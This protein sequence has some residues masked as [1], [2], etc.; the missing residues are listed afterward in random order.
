MVT[1]TYA[2]PGKYP[3]THYTEGT[4]TPL[5]HD[6]LVIIVTI[7]ADSCDFTAWFQYRIDSINC[8]EVRFTNYSAPMSPTMHFSWSFGDGSSSTDGNPVHVYAQSGTYYVCLV[9]Q[10]GSNC[11]KEYC[12]SVQVNCGH[13]DT[14]AVLPYFSWATDSATTNKTVFTNRTVAADASVHYTWDFG[15][16]SGSSH[17]IS[18]SHVYAHTGTYSVCLVAEENGGCRKQLCMAVTVTGIKPAINPCDS[19]RVSFTYSRN[20]TYPN[21][22]SFKAVSNDSSL[23]QLWSFYKKDANNINIPI[24]T[25]AQSNP[26]WT[27]TDTGWYRVCLVSITASNCRKEYCDS[28]HIEKVVNGPQLVVSTPNPAINTVTIEVTLDK[29]TQVMI[30]ILD[31]SGVTRMEF[32]ENG[33]TGNNRFTLPVERLS[34]GFYLVVIDAGTHRWYSRFQKG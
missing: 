11:Q 23:V 13:S 29:P 6:S 26:G 27:F 24:T 17:D 3:V 30:R 22:V 7:P 9:S 14:C 19:L 34:R 21:R 18:P 32:G 1:H 31:G 10:F 25:L 33:A 4:G 5:C 28:I 2:Q 8:K 20:S 15:D 16:S 12:D